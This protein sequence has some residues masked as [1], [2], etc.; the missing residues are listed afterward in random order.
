MQFEVNGISYF[1]NFNPSEGR[2]QLLYAMP[3]GIGR[4]PIIDDGGPLVLPPGEL[5]APATENAC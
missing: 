1:L 2:W 3:K 5:K 4:I